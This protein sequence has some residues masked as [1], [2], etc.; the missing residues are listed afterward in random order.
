MRPYDEF[1]DL[2][3]VERQHGR[4]VP[5][6]VPLEDVDD[7]LVDV[8]ARRAEADHALP[9]EVLDAVAP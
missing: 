6:A 1:L 3:E 7:L 9:G 4:L 5:V 8:E 2:L